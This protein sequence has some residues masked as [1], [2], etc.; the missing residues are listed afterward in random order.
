MGMGP[1][2]FGAAAAQY[3]ANMAAQDAQTASRAAMEAGRQ[4]EAL[5]LDVE[6]LFMITEA[7]W[8]ILKEKHGYTDDDLN[9]MVQDIDLRDGQ[10]DGKVAKKPNPPCQKCGRVLMARHPVC[11]YCGTVSVRGPFER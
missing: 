1:G 4:S 2:I 3:Q 8:N 6:K 10:L 9:V 7:L 11:I 5:S